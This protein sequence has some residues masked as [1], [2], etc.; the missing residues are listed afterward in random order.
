[1]L[2]KEASPTTRKIAELLRSGRI[3]P[4]QLNS[5]YQRALDTEYSRQLQNA[6]QIKRYNQFYDESR[7]TLKGNNA[8][9]I[10]KLYL[11]NNMYHDAKRRLNTKLVIPTEPWH[12]EADAIRRLSEDNA[13]QVANYYKKPHALRNYRST[14]EHPAHGFYKPKTTKDIN[15]AVTDTLER[16]MNMS[17]SRPA[18]LMQPTKNFKN[19]IYTPHFAKASDRVRLKLLNRNKKPHLRSAESLGVL[20]DY[21]TVVNNS[22]VVNR[23][24]VRQR[25][26]VEAKP[27]E[28]NAFLFNKL[29]AN[30]DTRMWKGFNKSYT[31]DKV[32]PFTTLNYKD[33]Y[34]YSGRPE[35]SAGYAGFDS[36]IDKLYLK[37]VSSGE[38]P[39]K[40]HIPSAITKKVE[41]ATPGLL[42]QYKPISKL[43]PSKPIV[44]K[45]SG[46]FGN[47]GKAL[48]FIR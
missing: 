40:P 11:R 5:I 37:P 24:N 34:F 4:K 48:K 6:E 10:N 8:H 43:V 41:L 18:L 33:N 22:K 2:V 29:K 35:V 46:L 19:L 45:L 23:N 7:G 21:E 28:A 38:N 20:N 36:P 15:K 12:A 31:L 30:P 3:T 39:F 27:D 44:G 25:W 32:K 9:D 16:R 14:P 17:F 42:N 47:M 26:F 13:R 1:M